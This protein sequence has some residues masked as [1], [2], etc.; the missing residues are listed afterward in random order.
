MTQQQPNNPLHG[1][2]LEMVLTRLVQHYGWRGLWQ[3]VQVQCFY[4]TVRPMK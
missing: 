2:T 4:N 3:H 1:I